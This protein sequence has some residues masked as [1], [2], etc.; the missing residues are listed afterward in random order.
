MR[1]VLYQIGFLTEILIKELSIYPEVLNE[2]ES[3]EC[4]HFRK[5]IVLISNKSNA[6]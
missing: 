5:L 6:I 4:H 2:I 3:G 1:I